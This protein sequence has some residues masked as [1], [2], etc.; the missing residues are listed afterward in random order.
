MMSRSLSSTLSRTKVFTLIELL[1]VIA[2]IALLAALLLPSLKRARDAGKSQAIARPPGYSRTGHGGQ[3][4]SLNFMFLDGHTELI[5]RD[6]SVLLA[7]A[8]T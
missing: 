2:I 3:N 5:L 8:L 4:D 1:V 7:S 6:D